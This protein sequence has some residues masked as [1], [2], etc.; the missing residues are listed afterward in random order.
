M[1]VFEVQTDRLAPKMHSI[2]SCTKQRLCAE[3]SGAI[4]MR[5]YMTKNHEDLA[6]LSLDK[7]FE[8]LLT[9]RALQQSQHIPCC[10]AALSLR[11]STALYG[12]RGL[13]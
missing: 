3:P 10:K 6:C 11:A 7:V 13:L 2:A 5:V 12:R 9:T 4:D 1:S 8:K